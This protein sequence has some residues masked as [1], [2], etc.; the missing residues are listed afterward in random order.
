M[1]IS[2]LENSVLRP[3]SFFSVLAMTYYSI[4]HASRS[5]ISVM[6]GMLCTLL[7]CFYRVESIGL[8]TNRS[9]TARW[10]DLKIRIQWGL[11][12]QRQNEKD[13]S[14]ENI[15]LYIISTRRGRTQSPH[16]LIVI[17]RHA[18]QRPVRTFHCGVGWM[19]IRNV[20]NKTQYEICIGSL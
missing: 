16:V 13:V 1:K 17:V 5:Y 14:D 8:P 2:F 20:R 3:M 11:L 12:V 15:V 7:V 18:K 10:H 9:T 19:G 6:T 4:R